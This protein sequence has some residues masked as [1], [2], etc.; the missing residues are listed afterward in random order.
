MM[1]NIP[2]RYAYTD[3]E[4]AS[5]KAKGFEVSK[6]GAYHYYS[7]KMFDK[8]MSTNGFQFHLR[9]HNPVEEGY[10]LCFGSRS[11]TVFSCRRFNSA[12]LPF[13]AVL[14]VGASQAASPSY[15]KIRPIRFST[16][17]MT[18]SKKKSTSKSH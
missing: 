15:S 9:S 8:F 12:T 3:E 14:Q 16:A 5:I 18:T 10:A 17:E 1:V 7:S 6:N 11:L 2:V 4:K 13:I